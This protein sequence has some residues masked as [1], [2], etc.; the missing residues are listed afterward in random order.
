MSGP[1]AL[2][3]DFGGTKVLAA[4]VDLSTGEVVTSQ[5]K[6]TNPADGPDELMGRIYE[7][8]EAALKS[9]TAG[10][11]E[12]IA[13]VGVGIAGQVDTEKGILL[14]APNLSQASVDIPITKLLSERFG[15]P[16]ALRNDVQIAAMGE[17]KFGAGK[18]VDD[19]ICAFVGTGIGG[20]IVRGGVLVPGASGTAGGIGHIVVDANG[21]LCGCGGRGHLEAY[22]SRPAITKAILGEIRRGR[23][24][25]LKQMIEGGREQEGG[26][27]IRSGILA[28]AVAEKDEL[29]VEAVT[30]AATYLGYGLASL[31]NFLN[32]RRIIL[33]GGVI[34]A[35][36]LLFT[37]A[38][39]RARREA[40][41]TPAKTVDIVKA[42]LG[43][44]AGVVGAALLGG[45][46]AQVA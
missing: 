32:P 24:T 38:V 25:V 5:K 46:A 42:G 9:W 21:R 7:V 6:R 2:G 35:V 15:A 22:A 45:Q 37:V 12:R 43:D 10:K 27:A 11:K 16:A 39:G 36:D 13:G 3:I 14:G 30:E 28:K 41:T 33:G 29:A 4:I 8:G 23:T 44:D 31:V 40:L 17:A 19:F 34:E 20:A 26:G 1:Y 18:G